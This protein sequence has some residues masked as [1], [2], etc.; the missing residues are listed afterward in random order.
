MLIESKLSSFIKGIQ[1]KGLDG[2]WVL[3]S[4][5][6]INLDVLEKLVDGKLPDDTSNCFYIDYPTPAEVE[7]LPKYGDRDPS[8]D[9]PKYNYHVLLYQLFEAKKVGKM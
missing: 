1:Q 7:G 6:F 5:L 3:P 2:K 8:S 9:G 4:R